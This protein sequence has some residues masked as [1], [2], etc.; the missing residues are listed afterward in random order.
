M[1]GCCGVEEGAEREVTSEEEKRKKKKR[2]TQPGGNNVPGVEKT[3]CS[4]DRPCGIVGWLV[5]WL[6][7]WIYTYYT[8]KHA[9]IRRRGGWPSSSQAPLLPTY[10]EHDVAVLSPCRQVHARTARLVLPAI[11]PWPLGGTKSRVCLGCVWPLVC[12]AADGSPVVIGEH[13]GQDQ[14][15]W[16]LECIIPHF[17]HARDCCE[18]SSGEFQPHFSPIGCRLLHVTLAQ[19][20]I[21]AVP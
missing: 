9:G 5:G 17:C 14:P 7:S 15:A 12:S 6:A 21:G 11:G 20:G 10:E 19:H 8:H 18:L 2:K 1:A 3:T 16:D 4:V 13:R